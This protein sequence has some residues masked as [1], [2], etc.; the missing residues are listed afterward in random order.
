MRP[1]KHPAKRLLEVAD[2][3]NARV[4]AETAA[5]E[6]AKADSSRSE[7]PRKKIGFVGTSLTAG[8]GLDAGNAFPA[9]IQRKIDSAGFSYDVVNAGVSGETT[10]GLLSRLDG[11]LGD[12]FDVVVLES[13]ANDGLRGVPVETVKQDLQTALDRIKTARPSARVV[14]VQMEALPNYGPQYTRAF[15]NIYPDLAKANGVRLAA[16]PA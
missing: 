8:L 15:H 3:A 11:L 14:L 7:S 10:N 5:P 9:M 2:S 16:V 13:G 1:T 4:V 6:P 12:P